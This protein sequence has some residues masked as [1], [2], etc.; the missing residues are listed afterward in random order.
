MVAQVNETYTATLELDP[1]SH[2]WMADIEGLPVHTWGRSLA[3]VKQY[4]IEAL[5]LHL[6]VPEAEVTGRINFARPQLPAPCSTPWT[7]QRPQRPTPTAP[8]QG[9]PKPNR[10][11]PERW[12]T[13]LTCLCGTRRKSSVSRTS[14]FSSCLPADDGLWPPSIGDPVDCLA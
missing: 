13:T 6:D 1:R 8:R 10:R 5:A 4:A 12:S 3:K 7:R 11:P 9:Q 2:Q 14:A